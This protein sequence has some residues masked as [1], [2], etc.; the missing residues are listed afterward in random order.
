MA[1]FQAALNKGFTKG[2]GGRFGRLPF[3]VRVNI[4]NRPHQAEARVGIHLRECVDRPAG[5]AEVHALNPAAMLDD[6]HIIGEARLDDL[7][8]VAAA[9]GSTG[10]LVNRGE[11]A[12]GL[13]KE[14]FFIFCVGRLTPRFTAMIVAVKNG[15]RPA[16]SW[17]FNLSAANLGWRNALAVGVGLDV[18]HLRNSFHLF[19]IFPEPPTAADGARA[20]QRMA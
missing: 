8:A 2:L 20:R 17:I 16:E 10:A 5:I 14:K 13:V 1:L 18:H 6:Q 4:Q 3:G 7:E 9:V 12:T 15:A 11:N 19:Q